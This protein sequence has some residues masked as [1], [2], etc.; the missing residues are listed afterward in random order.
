LAGV[1][2]FVKLE[3]AFDTKNTGLISKNDFLELIL[4]AKESDADTSNF[5]KI[6]KSLN[7]TPSK[8]PAA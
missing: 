6:A 3:K 4:E 5:H 1:I 2:N 8:V 7:A